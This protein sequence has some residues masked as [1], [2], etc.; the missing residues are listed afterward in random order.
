MKIVRGF[1]KLKKPDNVM[2]KQYRLGKMKQYQLGK[3]TK[4]IFKS[5]THT[6][7]NIWN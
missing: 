2:G 3:M 6:S 5:K 7:K 4:S 1:P